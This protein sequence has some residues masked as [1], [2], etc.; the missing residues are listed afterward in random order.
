[1]TGPVQILRAS[2]FNTPQNPF[3]FSDALVAIEDGGLAVAEGCIAACDDYSRVSRQFPDAAVRDLRGSYL[4]PGF[5]DTHVHYPQVRILGG[6]GYSVL[7]WLQGLTLPEEAKLAD[8]KYANQIS[9]EFLQQL[10]SHGTTTALVFGAHF[11]SAMTCF[12]EAGG[13][14]GLRIISGLVLSDR[15]LTPALQQTPEAAYEQ[16]KSLIRRFHRKGRLAYAVTPRF[17]LSASEPMLQVC[18]ALRREDASLHFTTHVNENPREVE[19]VARLFPWAADYLAVYERYHLAGRRSIFAHNIHTCDSQL[20]RLSVHGAAIAHCP[21]SNAALG[22]GIFPMKHH[23]DARVRFALGSDVGGGTGFGMMK[24]A[25]QA[26]LLQRVAPQAMTLTAA[27]MLY[28]TTRAGAEALD[29]D[30]EIGDFT[31][32]KAA[33]LVVLQAP[34][35]SPLA[36][37]LAAKVDPARALAAIFTLAGSECIREVQVGGEVIYDIAAN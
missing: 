28:L 29:M 4:L 21:C 32:G 37:V 18:E 1:M 15:G 24:E 8:T 7:D 30:A 23:L 19:E 10:K 27:Q 3:D 9:G 25:L 6:L 2:I 31:P 20:H 22:S 12:F 33:D 34:Q 17:A 36:G 26:Y 11:E 13:Q 5:V 16:S 14:S 35:K